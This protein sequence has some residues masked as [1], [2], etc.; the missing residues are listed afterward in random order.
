MKFLY[1]YS[2]ARNHSSGKRC[3]IASNAKKVKRR[4]ALARFPID[5]PFLERNSSW[6]VAKFLPF[7]TLARPIQL[8]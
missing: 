5:F 3:R 6:R 2:E 8:R 4:V 1:L 7:I